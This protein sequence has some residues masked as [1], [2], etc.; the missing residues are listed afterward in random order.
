MLVHGGIG[1]QADH[2]ALTISG[3]I[4][5]YAYYSFMPI[6]VVEPSLTKPVKVNNFAPV[7]KFEVNLVFLETK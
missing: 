5:G 6:V 1:T 7:L 2:N 4:I 3:Y